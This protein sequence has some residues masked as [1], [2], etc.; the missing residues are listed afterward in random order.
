MITVTNPGH[1]TSEIIWVRMTPWT[2]AAIQ[3]HVQIPGGDGEGVTFRKGSDN[4]TSTL[5][6][7][8]PWTEEGEAQYEALVGARLTIDNGLSTRTA[9]AGTPVPSQSEVP[10][11]IHFTLTVRE[12]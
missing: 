11:W 1:S 10:A 6:G 5:T 4:A 8:V 9:I 2:R 3:T 12:V 7:R